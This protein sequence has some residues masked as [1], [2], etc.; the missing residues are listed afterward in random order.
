[1]DFTFPVCDLTDMAAGNYTSMDLSDY[2]IRNGMP[3]SIMN[4]AYSFGRQHLDQA[5]YNMGY[6]HEARVINEERVDRLGRFGMPP[7]IDRW[8]GWIAPSYDTI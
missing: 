6:T 7:M 3:I 2:L 1:M 8:T 4:N 5:Y